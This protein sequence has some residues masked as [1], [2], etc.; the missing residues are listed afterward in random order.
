M[1]LLTFVTEWYVI[2]DEISIF[3]I[4]GK[5]IVIKLVFGIPYWNEES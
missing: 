2:Y 3:V 5:E 4:G 1:T